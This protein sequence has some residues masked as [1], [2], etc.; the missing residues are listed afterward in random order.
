MRK[1]NKYIL[2]EIFQIDLGEVKKKLNT[3]RF[4]IDFF[5]ESG[6]YYPPFLR[7]NYEFCLQVLSGRKK[8]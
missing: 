4:I 2:E 5:R 3:K 8:V 7:Y 1:M 6:Y